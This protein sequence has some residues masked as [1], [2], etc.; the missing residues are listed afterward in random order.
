MG[1][2]QDV[3]STL[4]AQLNIPSKDFLWSKNLLNP[5]TKKFAFF[6]WDNGLGFINNNQCVTFDNVGKTIL[7]SEKSLYE[8]ARKCLP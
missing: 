5:Y 3:A 2:Q 8:V 6:T 7:Q 4:L 1:S